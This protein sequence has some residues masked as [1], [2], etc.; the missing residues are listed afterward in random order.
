MQI[1]FDGTLTIDGIIYNGPVPYEGW[2][3]CWGLP[4]YGEL[5]P[6]LLMHNHLR[7]AR[8]YKAM[9]LKRGESVSLAHAIGWASRD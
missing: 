5:T 7:I 3:A 9:G 4:Q 6:A 1:Q 8:E 2:R